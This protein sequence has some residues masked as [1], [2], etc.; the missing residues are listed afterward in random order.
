[1]KYSSPVIYVITI[2]E[3]SFMRCTGGSWNPG[4]C[5]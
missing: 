5:S 1:M 2:T 3:D 4:G